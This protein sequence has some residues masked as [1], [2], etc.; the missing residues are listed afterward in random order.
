MRSRALLA[1]LTFATV[2]ASQIFS[3]PSARAGLAEWEAQVAAGA[4]AGYTNTNIASPI[5]ADI[6]V[7]SET[8][9][10][11]VS[12]EFIVN[13]TNDGVSSA[14]MGTAQSAALVTGD[15][16]GLKWEQWENTTHYGTTAFGVADFDSGVVNTPGVD[17]HLVFVNNSV[18][19]LLYVNG[20]LAATIAG[21]SPTLSGNVGIGQVNN[22]PGDNFDALTGTI[23][24]VAV[25]DSALNPEEI[26]A[27]SAAYFIPEPAGLALAIVGLSGLLAARR[28]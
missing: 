4:V 20:A 25:Y 1:S 22:A 13:A 11:G 27:H 6:G 18:D 19:T 3:S 14:L 9:G 2:V 16:A 24:G 12:Y 28:R 26:A 23:I 10:G 7:Y 5:V 21:S 8:T 15:R 17:T